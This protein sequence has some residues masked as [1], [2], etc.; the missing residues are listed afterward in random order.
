MVPMTWSR[1]VAPIT[2]LV[3][4]F[5]LGRLRL[6]GPDYRLRGPDY[7]L[8]GHDYRLS[9]LPLAPASLCLRVLARRFAPLLLA[10][11]SQCQ[12]FEPWK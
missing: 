2:D 1:L 5:R 8:G 6:S 12:K 9:P 10:P 3:V 7:R 4:P 11:N